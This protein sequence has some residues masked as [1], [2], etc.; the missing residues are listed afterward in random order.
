MIELEQLKKRV[1]D[2]ELIVHSLIEQ[3]K[4]AKRYAPPSIEEVTQYFISKGSSE[5]ANFWR[6]YDCKNWMVGKNKMMKWKSSAA[7]WINK[8]KT[9]VQG[10]YSIEDMCR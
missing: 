6:F 5:G 10:G 4:P 8:N 9:S 3:K 7:N 1:S 2:L